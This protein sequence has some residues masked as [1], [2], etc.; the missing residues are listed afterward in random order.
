MIE[1]ARKNKEAEAEKENAIKKKEKL[2]NYTLAIAR[3]KSITT[4]K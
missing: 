2:K 1:L 3:G 4:G